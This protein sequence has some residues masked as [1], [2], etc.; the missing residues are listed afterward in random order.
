MAK[1]EFEPRQSASNNIYVGFVVREGVIKSNSRV[2]GLRNWKDGFL[3]T[4]TAVARE[5]YSH[6]GEMF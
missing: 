2:L 1:Q 5:E 3:L 6:F 4:E